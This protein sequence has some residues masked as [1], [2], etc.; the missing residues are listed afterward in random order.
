MS[1][2]P[3][4]LGSLWIFQLNA[5]CLLLDNRIPQNSSPLKKISSIKTSIPMGYSGTALRISITIYRKLT[6]ATIT[7]TQSIPSRYQRTSVL[8]LGP[9]RIIMLVWTSG[10]I[11]SIIK[12]TSSILAHV[13]ANPNSLWKVLSKNTGTCTYMCKPVLNIS[14]INYLTSIPT[15]VMSLM[16]PKKVMHH[17]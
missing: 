14:D 1:A 13:K 12:I 10:D 11:I 8:P 15:L 16:L 5:L 9:L 7:L 4:L 6:E 2:L 17:P 3:M